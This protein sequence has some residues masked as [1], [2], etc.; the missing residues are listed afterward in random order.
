MLTAGTTAPRG[1]AQAAPARRARPG[2]DQV[3]E[4]FNVQGS[5]CGQVAADFGACALLPTC[6]CVVPRA[7]IDRAGLDGR[8]GYGTAAC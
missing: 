3:L 5:R 8:G 1:R 6:V 4:A 2:R 7:V